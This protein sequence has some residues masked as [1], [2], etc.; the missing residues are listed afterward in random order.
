MHGVLLKKLNFNWE[1]MYCKDHMHGQ[2]N[3]FW[4]VK[5]IATYICIGCYNHYGFWSTLKSKKKKKHYKSMEEVLRFKVG[6]VEDFKTV[7][8]GTIII[9]KSLL[10]TILYI[11]I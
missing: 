10:G 7:G 9:L 3:R 2:K 8:V 4:L 6:R 5:K 11:P 1:K